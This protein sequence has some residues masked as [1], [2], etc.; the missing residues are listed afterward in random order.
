MENNIRLVEDDKVLKEKAK[1]KLKDELEKAKDKDFAEPVIG[2]LLKRCAEDKGV[3]EDVLLEHKTWEKCYSYIYDQA[4]K[5]AQGN[6]VAVRDDVVYEWAE[7]YFHKDDKEEK[8]K[9]ESKKKQ[10]GKMQIKKKKIEKMEEA[11]EEIKKVEAKSS[12]RNE[13]KKKHKDTEELEGQMSIF[14]LGL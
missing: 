1:N 11:K 3:V 4:R 5:Q 6:S 10:E 9:D 2:Y 7:D 14:D 8:A 12:K 13:D